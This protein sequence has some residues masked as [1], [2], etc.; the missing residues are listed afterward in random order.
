ML[1][2]CSLCCSQN[3]IILIQA[4]LQVLAIEFNTIHKQI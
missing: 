2:F 1:L 3:N 4:E